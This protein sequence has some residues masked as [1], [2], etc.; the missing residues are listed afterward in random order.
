MYI[1]KPFY[2]KENE[3]RMYEFLNFYKIL[4]LAQPCKQF[5][6]VISFVV[7]MRT[8]SKKCRKYMMLKTYADAYKT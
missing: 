7:R 6:V 5:P 4:I 3:K 8:N 2:I 1:L